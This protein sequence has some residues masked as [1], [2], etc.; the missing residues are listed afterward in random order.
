MNNR[1]WLN[2][3]EQRRR[4]EARERWL[5]TAMVSLFVIAGG[6]FIATSIHDAFT[7]VAEQIESAGRQ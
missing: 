6:Y 1:E 5:L 3:M 7:G 2:Q 4:G